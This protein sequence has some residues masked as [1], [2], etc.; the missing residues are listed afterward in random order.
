[1]DNLIYWLGL[2]ILLLVINNT[3][4]KYSFCLDNAV[5][6]EKHK[7]LLSLENKVPLSGFFFFVPIIFLLFFKSNQIV[8]LIT[9][10]LFTL[11]FLSDIKIFSSPRLRLLFQFFIILIFVYL[12]DTIV[13]DTRI[14]TVNSLMTNNIF[15]IL[16]IT[17]F[18]LVLI[19][20][21]NFI[22]GTNNLCSLNFLIVLSFIGIF[23]FKF[24]Y[25]EKFNQIII[26]I[27]AVFVFTI[28]NFFGKNFLGDGGVY[29]LSFFI[30]YSFT[31]LSI[32]EPDI[33]PYFIANLLWYP[34]FENLF[35]IVRR[36]FVKKK[37]YLADNDHLHHLI[38]KFLSKKIVKKKYIISS[39]C[40]IIINSMLIISYILGYFHYSE[41]Y[42]Q[43]IIILIN[44]ILYSFLYLKLKKIINA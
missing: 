1:M 23:Y 12:A 13:I 27:Q 11:G 16:L 36:I 3:L 37:N 25:F 41:T 43:V 15:R 4:I 33:S 44:I 6:N 19:N 5:Q 21:F 14:S 31:E 35:S 38:Y 39:L 29:G 2:I 26:L 28:F 17:F 24:G 22:D 10:T 42:I 18:L 34:A 7:I 40:G 20:G 8:V 32:L 9:I 30:G